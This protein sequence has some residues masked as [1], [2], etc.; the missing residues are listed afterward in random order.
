MNN[1]SL[2]GAIRRR[3]WIIILMAIAGGI[4]GA[5]PQPEKVEE[6]VRTFNATHTLILNDASSNQS[7]G[8][9]ISR[10]HRRSAHSGC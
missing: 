6:Q 10:Q 2:L 3:W 5:L 8:T 1:S 7:A 9:V 4:F